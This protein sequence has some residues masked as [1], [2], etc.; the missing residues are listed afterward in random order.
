MLDEYLP[1]ASLANTDHDLADAPELQI[2]DLVAS[3]HQMLSQARMRF[4]AARI[5]IGALLEVIRSKGLWVEHAATFASYLEEYGLNDSAAYLYMRV[6]RRFFFD[7]KLSQTQIN[8]L[9]LVSMRVL[10]IAAR[11]AT[12]ANKDDILAIVTTLNERDARVALSE[13]GTNEAESTP[14]LP[15]HRPKSSAKVAKIYR[16]FRSLPDDQRLELLGLMRLP[17]TGEQPPCKP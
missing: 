11:I 3:S 9:S 5:E 2:E 16:E 4:G 1:D 13:L 10:D 6:A 17:S 8:S 12:P 14:K 15:D 7:L